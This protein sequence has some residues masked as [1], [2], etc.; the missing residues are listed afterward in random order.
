MSLI[1]ARYLPAL[2]H[3]RPHVK[4]DATMEDV[5]RDR[6]L[7]TKKQ[8]RALEFHACRH[9]PGDGVYSFEIRH[10]DPKYSGSRV[11]LVGHWNGI[12]ELIT[13]QTPERRR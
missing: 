7:R 4:L 8:E 11:Y 13:E 6:V 10:S 5:P 12:Y 2:F 3:W 9:L 1:R